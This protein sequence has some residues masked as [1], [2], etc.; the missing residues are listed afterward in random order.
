MN[1]ARQN[2]IKRIA[3]S[4]LVVIFGIGLAY[5]AIDT[6]SG[7]NTS[8]QA[9]SNVNTSSTPSAMSMKFPRNPGTPGTPLPNTDCG[10]AANCSAADGIL[11]FTQFDYEGYGCDATNNRMSWV[12][13]PKGSGRTVARLEIDDNDGDGSVPECNQFGGQRTE[14]LRFTPVDQV[15]GNEAWFA[16]GYFFGDGTTGDFFKIPS[17]PTPPQASAPWALLMQNY[18]RSAT[19]NPNPPQAIQIADCPVGNVNGNCNIVLKVQQQPASDRHYYTLGS[20]TRGHWQYFVMYVKFDRAGAGNVK[21]WYS[22]D[23]APDTSSAPM[24]DLPNDDAALAGSLN[25]LYDLDGYPKIGLY[26]LDGEAADYPWIAYLWGYGRG[27]TATEA[28][29]NAEL[30]GDVTPPAAV[31]DLRAN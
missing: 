13:D 20:T 28:M 14:F 21:I 10:G 26:R 17:S 31:S 24:Y 29:D 12:A 1:K 23:T 7:H 19:P 18:G 4:T 15:Q 22:L 2:P 30:P 16:W 27:A 3:V 11:D 8:A 9:A 6:L 25:T 5:I